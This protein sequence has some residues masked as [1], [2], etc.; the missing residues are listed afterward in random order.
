[1]RTHHTKFHDAMIYMAGGMVALLAVHAHAQSANDAVVS[2]SGSR[3]TVDSNGKC[4]RTKWMK[5]GDPCA[6]KVV[7]QQVTSYVP[8][9]HWSQEE[10]TVYFKFNSAELDATA[11]QKISTIAA[12][13]KQGDDVQ[14]A[15]V[16]G[17]ADRIGSHS[18]NEALSK[19]RAQAVQQYLIQQGVSQPSNTEVR[20][21][22]KQESSH[23]QCPDS[24]SHQALIDCLQPDRR[25][26]I[27]I[28]YL[29]RGN[30]TP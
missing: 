23:A 21:L 16:V 19:R 18:Y 26:E 13:L 22:G 1:M 11:Q 3:Y 10:R 12:G 27:V 15:H 2:G 8:A 5:D 9:P 30:T 29:T 4:V 6:P 14:A 7:T 17:F 20:W 24:L 28:D 25:V